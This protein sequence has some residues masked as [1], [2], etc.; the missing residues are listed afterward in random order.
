MKGLCQGAVVLVLG[1]LLLVAPPA[2]I[3]TDPGAQPQTGAHEGNHDF[4]FDFGTW[5]TRSSRLL[6]PLTGSHD[7]VEMDGITVVTKIW[8]G[9]ANLAEYRAAG[10]AG[11]VELLALRVYNPATRQWSINFATPNVGTLGAVP[12]V[13]EFRDGRVDF[14]DQETINGRAVLVRF[15]LWDVTAEEARSE[16]AFSADGGK[17]WEVNWITQYTRVSP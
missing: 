6:H 15:S 10:P 3:A 4:D 1:T 16:Q 12:G 17:S 13:G 7:W 11:V 14:Y 5:K 9:R 8:N 2:S